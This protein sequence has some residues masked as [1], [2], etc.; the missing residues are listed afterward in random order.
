MKVITIAEARLAGEVHYFTGKQ[1][2]HG[3]VSLRFVSNKVCRDCTLKRA[4]D[5]READPVRVRERFQRH[6]VANRAEKL[7]YQNR[8]RQNNQAAYNKL[9]RGRSRRVK[10]A[11]PKWVGA[12]ERKLIRNFY[13]S[14]PSGKQVD[15]EIPLQGRNVC[16]LH[17]LSNLQYLTPAENRAKGASWTP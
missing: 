1:C 14:T 5:E 4:V 2:R 12:E 10:D 6:H 9:M 17:V 13:S 8:W 11:T 7:A 16:G 15:H 3:H